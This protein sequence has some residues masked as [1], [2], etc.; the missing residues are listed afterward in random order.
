[1][2][3]SYLQVN[4]YTVMIRNILIF[5]FS[6]GGFS[7]IFPMPDYQKADVDAFFANHPPPYTSAQFNNSGKVRACF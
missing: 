7:D 1:M 3:A 2:R 6:G 5:G 4:S